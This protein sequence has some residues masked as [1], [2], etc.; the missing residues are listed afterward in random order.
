MNT[1]GAALR[2][3]SVCGFALLVACASTVALFLLGCGTSV[4]STPSPPVAAEPARPRALPDLSSCAL[5]ARVL[6]IGGGAE[7]SA[8]V[9]VSDGFVV[10]FERHDGGR[11]DPD[12]FAQHVR[13]DGT[14]DVDAAVSDV[15]V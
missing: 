3:A 14:H 12:L 8:P 1:W 5:S 13:V 6:E 10:A 7:V 9:E 4:R 2:G 15:S 11:E